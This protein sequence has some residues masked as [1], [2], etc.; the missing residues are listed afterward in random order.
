MLNR[1][2]LSLLDAIPVRHD[3][4]DLRRRRT[5]SVVLHNR[6]GVFVGE[7]AELQ[8]ELW[9]KWQLF[10]R[11]VERL[12]VVFS[13]TVP[14]LA[15]LVRS[16]VDGQ[17]SKRLGFASKIQSSQN[18]NRAR[19]VVNDIVETYSGH[20]HNALQMVVTQDGKPIIVAPLQ[21]VFI[22]SRVN[23]DIVQCWD[24]AR[25]IKHPSGGAVEITTNKTFGKIRNTLVGVV[26][27]A[28]LSETSRF[29]EYE[30]WAADSVKKK[31]TFLIF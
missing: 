18:T 8:D 31:K 4:N 22:I 11:H 6:L 23:S 27:D 2:N 5:V 14:D 19:S 1:H 10:Q 29:A 7:G 20:I 9:K 21:A 16:Y 15:R 28:W 26:C 3:Q 24:I 17:F 13:S 30:H 12:S 25:N